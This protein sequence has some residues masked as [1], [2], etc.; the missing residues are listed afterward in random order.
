MGIPCFALVNLCDGSVRLELRILEKKD[1]FLLCRLE[2]FGQKKK[3]FQ[4]SV[5][6]MLSLLELSSKSH[7]FSFM[8]QTSLFFTTSFQISP[9]IWVSAVASFISLF[10]ELFSWEI[11]FSNLH[12]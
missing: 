4:I 3:F 5:I 6:Y 7:N 1:I 12:F 2:S 8:I 9:P 11:I 10:T